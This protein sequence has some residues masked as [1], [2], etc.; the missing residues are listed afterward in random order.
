M[1]YEVV[2][3][4]GWGQSKYF[5]H[6]PSAAAIREAAEEAGVG[7]LVLEI[8][9]AVLGG[10]ATWPHPDDIFDTPEEFIQHVLS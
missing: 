4:L 8:S 9:P 3:E 7:R 1:L 2:L 5:V 6:A 10:P